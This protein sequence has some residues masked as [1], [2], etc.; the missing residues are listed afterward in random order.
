MDIFPPNDPTPFEINK[1]D[2]DGKPI[3][4]LPT[5]G[6]RAISP[7]DA[8][9]AVRDVEQYHMAVHA[10]IDGWRQAET[11]LTIAA[12]AL[13][14]TPPQATS[15]ARLSFM[16]DPANYGLMQWPGMQ[17]E[18]LR[19]VARENI[20]P[21]M[22]IQSRVADIRRYSSLST[23]PWSAGWKIGL[24]DPS[25]TISRSDQEDIE[26]AQRFIW[27]CSRDQAH[28]G[29]LDRDAHHIPS[30]ETFL[31][32]AVENSLTF[33]GWAIWTDRDNEGR[34]RAFSNLP[35]GLIRLALPGRGY[36]GNPNVFAALVD[37]T[38]SVVSTFTREEMVW[39]VRNA[40]NDPDVIG[41]G[42][43]EIEMTVRIIQGFAAAID[44]NVNTFD[45]N[46][47]PNGLLKLKG[48][49]WQQDQIDALQREWVNMKRGIS[50]MWGLPVIA[51]PED[52]DIE[53]MDFMDLKGQEIR[54][55]DH[56]NLMA[57]VYC[58]VSQYP[59]RRMGMFAS[60]HTRD[61]QPVADGSVEIQGVDDPG[62]PMMLTFI[63][64]RVNE[65][66][67]QM[68]WPHLKFSF[69]NKSPKEDARSYEAIKQA[70]TLKESRAEADLPSLTKGAPD[71]IEPMLEIM[72][73]CPENS[74]M[75]GVFQTLA[76]EILK[77]KLGIN[78][79]PNQQSTPGAPF[80][81]K[82][83]PAVSQAH[84]HRS[85]VRRSGTRERANAGADTS[86]R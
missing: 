14:A 10:A 22:V 56:L 3:A 60:G 12:K 37:D 35:A 18:S 39:C 70:R 45:K 7:L 13:G 52:G 44:L 64:H 40:R 82:K 28:D 17:P 74:A 66:L 42:Y 83:D 84:G 47:I 41:Y 2:P 72:Q 48:D 36:K 80:P 75:T 49:F 46:G 61:N 86:E 77:D 32:E 26:E 25:R 59:I 63:E 34:V 31:C 16:P 51:V 43:S 65:Y 78:D 81:E 69:M 33:D 21:R 29:P 4:R 53:L 8:V 15:Y 9:F 19:K 24:K 27:N 85:G 73:Y 79:E 1:A 55:K 6:T 62:L 58:I 76:V 57:G 30:F 67:L 68:N 54:Y 50:K 5:L 71:W 23:H 38:G 20:L 11:S